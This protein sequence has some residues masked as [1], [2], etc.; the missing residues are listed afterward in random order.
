MEDERAKIPERR[1]VSV[2]WERLSRNRIVLTASAAALLV[3]DVLHGGSGRAAAIALVFLI[4]VAVLVPGSRRGGAP[5]RAGEAAARRMDALSAVDL[6]AAVED[7]LYIFDR[8]G[9]VVL[10]NAAA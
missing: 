1:A 9:A 2:V 8:G 3:L 5:A 7:P 10:A 6:A 4:G